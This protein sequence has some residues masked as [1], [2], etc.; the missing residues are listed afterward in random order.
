[1]LLH[2]TFFIKHRLFYITLFSS[3]FMSSSFTFHTYFCWFINARVVIRLSLK[4]Y[5]RN[6]ATCFMSTQIAH[7]WFTQIKKEVLVCW[8]TYKRNVNLG[9]TLIIELVNQ[10]WFFWLFIKVL[11]LIFWFFLNLFVWWMSL[12][13]EIIVQL[14]IC[15]GDSFGF[16]VFSIVCYVFPAKFEVHSAPEIRFSVP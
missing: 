9:S 5:I 11:R 6:H 15:F 4:W 1:M 16:E 2:F 12:W 13:V 8:R 14:I 3:L 10:F 7:I